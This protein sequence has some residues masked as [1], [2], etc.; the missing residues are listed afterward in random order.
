MRGDE[1]GMLEGDAYDKVWAERVVDSDAVCQ[2][3]EPE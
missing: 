3:W 1:V 2:E